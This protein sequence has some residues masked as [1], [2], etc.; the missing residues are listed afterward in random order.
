MG[1]KINI[2]EYNPCW[3]KLFSKEQQRIRCALGDL[4]LDIEHIGSTAVKGLAAKPVIDVMVAI[5]KVGYFSTCIKLLT[6]AGYEYAPEHETI[7][8]DRCYFRRHVN[9]VR[10]CNLHLVKKD[11]VAWNDL[12]LFR[13]YLRT[14]LDEAFT[15]AN[16]KRELAKQEW[17]QGIEYAK[18]KTEY[19]KLILK[20]A[21]EEQRSG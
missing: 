13:D 19:V 1:K 21:A 9:N 15:Y 7:L 8:S 6:Q 2:V 12:L 3:P 4:A 18:A 17:S 16:L 20:V 14:H 10:I 5:R 11:S